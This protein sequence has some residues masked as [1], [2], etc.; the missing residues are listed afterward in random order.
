MSCFHSN[1]TVLPFLRKQSCGLSDPFLEGSGVVHLLDQSLHSHH[2][3]VG[4]AGQEA[5]PRFRIPLNLA[6]QKA[7]EHRRFHCYDFGRRC[8]AVGVTFSIG[9]AEDAVV[10]RPPLRLPTVP[11][12]YSAGQCKVITFFQLK[13]DFC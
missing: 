8:D 6:L 11:L 4:A 3:I 5:Q 9:P 13:I 7:P 12:G 1:A 10:A 2:S